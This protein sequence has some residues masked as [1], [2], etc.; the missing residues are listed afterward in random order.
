M[1]VLGIL[2]TLLVIVA[3]YPAEEPE[4]MGCEDEDEV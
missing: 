2:L 1:Y 4:C 3:L